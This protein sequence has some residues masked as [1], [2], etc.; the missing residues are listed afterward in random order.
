[1]ADLV[2]M[3]SYSPSVSER[4]QSGFFVILLSSCDLYHVAQA[5]RIMENVAYLESEFHTA[6]Y[7]FTLPGGKCIEGRSPRVRDFEVGS[8]GLEERMSK[9]ACVPLA[10]D[11]SAEI[12]A[13]RGLKAL[14]G[15]ESE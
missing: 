2:G 15:E 8:S 3:P 11:I 14:A 1:V 4:V 6:L 9:E 13:A 12:C 10:V 7:P 5:Q